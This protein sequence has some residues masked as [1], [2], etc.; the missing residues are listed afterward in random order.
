LKLTTCGLERVAQLGYI[1]HPTGQFDP[2][3]TRVPSAGRVP[4][5]ARGSGDR[6]LER[7]LPSPSPIHRLLTAGALAGVGGEELVG[8]VTD[9]CISTRSFFVGKGIGFR[10]Q[11]WRFSGPRMARRVVALVTDDEDNQRVLTGS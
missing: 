9:L 3:K 10:L 5:R 4:E 11:A 8:L 7:R 2:L 6:R 1:T